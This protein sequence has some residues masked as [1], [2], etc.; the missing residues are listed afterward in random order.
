MKQFLTTFGAA[1]A[2][3]FAALAMAPSAGAAVLHATGG[4]GNCTTELLGCSL[5]DALASADDGDVIRV[6]AGVHGLGS[7]VSDATPGVSVQG[8]PDE[9]RPVIAIAGAASGLRLTNGTNLSGV[10]IVSTSDVAVRAFGGLIERVRISAHGSGVAGIELG[11]GAILRNSTVSTSGP[12]SVGVLVES[13]GTRTELRGASVVAAGGGATAALVSPTGPWSSSLRAVNSVLRGFSG[14]GDV[15][16]VTS[17]SE[18]ATI[19]LDHSSTTPAG[20]SVAGPGSAIDNSR[21]PLTADPLFVDRAN[22]DL[23]QTSASP[24]IDGGTADL[25]GDG[26]V[27]AA[28]TAAAGASDLD[29]TPRQLGLPDIGSDEREMPPIVLSAEPVVTD[30]RLA[31]RVVVQPRGLSTVVTAEWSTGS[32]T[33]TVSGTADA[34]GNA[35]VSVDLP[36]SDVPPGAQIAVRA[37]ASNSAGTSLSDESTVAVP[38]AP[39]TT[40]ITPVAPPATATPAPAPLPGALP[41]LVSVKLRDH[42]GILAVKLQCKQKISCRGLVMLTRLGK[43][44]RWTEFKIARG[45]SKTVSLTLTSAQ[46]RK[47]R[48]DAAR[49]VRV[50]LELRSTQMG[51]S[52]QAIRIKGDP[53]APTATAKPAAPVAA[54]KR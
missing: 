39:V 6:H 21:S 37:R 2:L 51:S 13:D 36:L 12:A 18:T 19:V 48:K 11:D 14:A 49:G 7:A 24:T 28:D 8:A 52:F 32:D 10:D 9:P 34:S 3:L 26:N 15:R 29:G 54:A 1:F 38:D 45:A 43:T 17:A 30:G 40:T 20:T 47:L 50:L 16:A 46:T 41:T 35:P 5:S 27:D 33:A 25:D 53:K 22:L 31:L 44:P 42:W 4:S 23:R